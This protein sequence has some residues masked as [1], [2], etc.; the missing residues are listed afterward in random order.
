MTGIYIYVR[1][2]EQDITLENKKKNPTSGTYFLQKW[3]ILW[4]F[5]YFFNHT[6][7]NLTFERCLSEAK[8]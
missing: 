7:L 6:A 8:T 3:V 1:H 5:F 2:A 4:I